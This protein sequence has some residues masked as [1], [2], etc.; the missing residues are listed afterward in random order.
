M[1]SELQKQILDQMGIEQIKGLAI[2]LLIKHG[3]LKAEKEG[4]CVALKNIHDLSAMLQDSM[5]YES[6]DWHSGLRDIE[7][8]S[9][10]ALAKA[11]GDG[12]GDIQINAGQGDS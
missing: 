6:T 12:N 7:E 8:M 2:N 3:A 1:M 11:R 10:E 4:L 5:S 9:G